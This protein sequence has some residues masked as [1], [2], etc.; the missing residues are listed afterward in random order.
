MAVVLVALAAAARVAVTGTCDTTMLRELARRWAPQAVR[1][2]AD[3]AVFPNP[4][5]LTRYSTFVT[6]CW[7]QRTHGVLH[8]EADEMNLYV[9]SVAENGQHTFRCS[10]TTCTLTEDYDTFREQTMN[11]VN[12]YQ[13]HV[14]SNVHMK[15]ADICL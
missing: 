1:L 12:W 14:E 6:A 11:M 3:T 13:Q 7:G 15:D 8:L 5:H 9:V 2:N 10:L 4:S